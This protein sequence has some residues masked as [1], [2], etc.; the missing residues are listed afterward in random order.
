MSFQVCLYWFKELLPQPVK[1]NI[2][3]APTVWAANIK[4][5]SPIT[6]HFVK[7]KLCLD[8]SINIPG[9]GLWQVQ[10]SFRLEGQIKASSNPYVRNSS[11]NSLIEASAKLIL[12]WLVNANSLRPVF[13]TFYSILTKRI[14]LEVSRVNKMSI[15]PNCS[16]SINEYRLYSVYQNRFPSNI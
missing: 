8:A 16:I 5:T 2:F 9:F 13:L 12:C 6:T 7:S 14:W 4:P 15:S 10:P 11:W 3:V 1:T